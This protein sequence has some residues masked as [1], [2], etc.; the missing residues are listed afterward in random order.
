MDAGTARGAGR[1]A[2]GSRVAMVRF[3]DGA[4]WAAG[5]ASR[6]AGGAASVGAVVCA[7]VAFRGR[8]DWW[9]G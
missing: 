8:L 9:D 2:G 4:G 7:A 6:A 3:A 1:I 5:P